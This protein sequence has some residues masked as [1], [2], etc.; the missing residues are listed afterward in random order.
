[1]WELVAFLLLVAIPVVL[2]LREIPDRL[3]DVRAGWRGLLYVPF[4]V[5]LLFVAAFGAWVLAQQVPILQWGWLGENIIAAPLAD[6]ARETGSVQ[7]P[8]ATGGGGSAGGSGT[9]DSST[10][11][12][13]WVTIAV[14]VP[15]MV[16]ALLIFNYR[17]EAYY[18]DSLR[19]VAIWAVLHLIMGIPI[20]AVIPIFTVGLAYKA[21]HDWK[22][23]QTV[24]VAHLGTN[25]VLVGLILS[26]IVA[27]VF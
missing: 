25:L 27:G 18:R 13:P 1:M 19:D 4:T 10:L 15:I 3:R 24:Y 26:I 21:I 12:G 5:V 8:G 6:A 7:T 14:F 2:N 11:L 17:E 20:F 9:G 22:G 23:L 16:L